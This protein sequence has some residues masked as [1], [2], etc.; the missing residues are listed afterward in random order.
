MTL[1]NLAEN[2]K[3]L[4]A[5]AEDP[6]IDS[7]M[8]A[9]TMEAIEGEIDEKLDNYAV[10]INTIKTNVQQIKDEE[11][12]LADMRRSMENK[13]KKMLQV[14]T[15]MMTTTDHQKIKTSRYSFT[16]QKNP[17]S[18]VLDE[19][20]IENIPDEYIIIP[21]PVVDKAK[22]KADLKAGKDLDGIAHLEQSVGVRIR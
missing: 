10:I 8:L 14:M 20:Y 5:M 1:Y 21:D 3:L 16:V 13:Q 12:R 6:E 4:M 11:N 15:Y 18:L 9:D 22:L 17:P 2:Y 7:E 19:Q